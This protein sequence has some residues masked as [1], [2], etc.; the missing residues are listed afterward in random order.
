M[1]RVSLFVGARK[2]HSP[3][4]TPVGFDTSRHLINTVN[5]GV[6]LDK[7][8]TSVVRY[9]FDYSRQRQTD[10]ALMQSAPPKISSSSDENIVPT[11]SS[12]VSI[13][14][15]PLLVECMREFT[16][17]ETIEPDCTAV[18]KAKVHENFEGSQRANHEA[19]SDGQQGYDVSIK[20]QQIQLT[21]YVKRCTQRFVEG[22]NEK[23]RV[24]AGS[25]FLGIERARR[26]APSGNQEYIDDITETQASNSTTRDPSA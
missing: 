5:S 23:R 16:A 2:T 24:G 26:T 9:P 6:T 25:V 14:L 19:P 10:G 22:Q 15:L 11:R 7:P 20:Y 18:L 17:C 21:R 8:V 3:H 12:T 1:K 4:V 13:L